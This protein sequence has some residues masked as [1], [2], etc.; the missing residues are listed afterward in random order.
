MDRNLTIA[1][2]GNP[3]S[4]KTTLFNA[5][6]GSKQ[7]VGNWPGV[8]VE[9]KEGSYSYKG[10]IL[11]I[12]DLPGSYSLSPYSIEEIVTRDYILSDAADVVLNIVDAVN[13]ERNLYFSIQL[14]E[15]G[16]PVVIALNMMDMAMKR[17][18]NINIDELSRNLGVKIVPIVASKGIGF[19]N[20]SEAIVEAAEKPD[21][22]IKPVRVDYGKDID[23]EVSKIASKLENLEPKVNPNP[24]WIAL[25]VLEQD[26]KILEY[27]KSQY[28][29][30]FE[31]KRYLDGE[32]DETIADMR[33]NFITEQV[34]KSVNKE[35]E[36][37]LSGSEKLDRI[38]THRVLALPIFAA[39]MF[40]IFFATFNIGG[41]FNSMIDE[42]FSGP[43]SETTASALTSIGV[44]EW[45]ISVIVD[46]I[47][48]GVGSVLTFLPNIAVLFLC[49]SILE[50]SG[51]MA[52]IAF[53]M[54]R[55]MRKI[56]LSG[57]AFV[58][59]L[60]GFGCTI[61]AVMGTR[62]LENQKERLTAI[63]IA[64]FMSCNAR[65]PVYVLFAGVFFKDHQSLV[66]FSLYILGVLVAILSGLLFKKT[67][68]KAES[69]AF[70]MELPPYR[71]PTLKGTLS[72]IWEKLKGYIVKAGTVILAASVV[73]WFILNYNF[74]GPTDMLNS[75]GASIG[76]V[77]APVFSFAGFGNWQAS[78]SLLTGVV[79][80]ESVVS[81]MSIIY[82]LSA[83]VGEAAIEGDVSGFSS[84]ISQAF[85]GLSAYAFMAFVLLYTPCVAAI[86]V[87]KK[88]TASWK[89][90]AFS[91]GYQ[92][93][94]AT[95]VATLIYQIGSLFL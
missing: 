45:L 76:K 53:I 24:E 27:L 84:T 55:A 50:D 20:L 68:L 62:T 77:I 70:V 31:E 11:N 94:V 56:G 14:M 40:L 9:K 29:L 42:F 59:L 60:I 57:K 39:I 19:G 7:H 51:Y 54:D 35:F 79:A 23:S 46:G 83:S 18:I 49:I 91:V 61:P 67:I 37:K 86:A 5:L 71:F 87:I 25:K 32:Y 89:W 26:E 34:K 33:Y 72:N 47:I 80:K 12:A 93:L 1:L 28:S 63:L 16:K 66:I 82:G 69:S 4:G 85:S 38:L 95:L 64:P 65:L 10:Q 88:E 52:R 58:P 6:T 21:S 41:I 17:G 43:V 15:L 30:D 44:S 90:T 2:A 74:S 13:I 8:T 92:F 78:L 73:V 75:F 48:A 3:N 36:H 22:R 81:S